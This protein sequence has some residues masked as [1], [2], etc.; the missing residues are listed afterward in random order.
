[1]ETPLIPNGIALSLLL[2]FPGFFFQTSNASPKP[3]LDVTTDLT[4][5]THQSQFRIRR[6]PNSLFR[7]YFGKGWCS[8]LDIHL[9]IRSE[10]TLLLKSCRVSNPIRFDFGMSQETST[11]NFPNLR[12]KR[13]GGTFIL[14]R[15]GV[16]IAQ[17]NLLGQ[18]TAIR[19]SHNGHS[20]SSEWLH[21]R[22]QSGRLQEIG[23]WKDEGQARSMATI[24]HDRA[25]IS[26]DPTTN[27]IL[28]LQTRTQGIR[29]HYQGY[30]LKRTQNLPIERSPD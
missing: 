26:I 27:T 5:E 4:L 12:L 14:K 6:F 20:P 18:P 15:E 3:S 24:A 8:D 22:Y 7:G 23:F 30:R 16:A 28:S 1:M 17:F 19:S 13:V 2:V 21:F 11:Q 9:E 10:N 25:T 29:Y